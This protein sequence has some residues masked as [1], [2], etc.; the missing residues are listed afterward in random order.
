MQKPI[1]QKAINSVERQMGLRACVRACVRRVS[2][3]LAAGALAC[4]CV[5]A[6]L[7]VRCGRCKRR[8]WQWIVCAA[9]C[10]RPVTTRGSSRLA[11][12]RTDSAAGCRCHHS[13]MKSAC[14]RNTYVHTCIRSD[15]YTYAD[16]LRERERVPNEIGVANS[17]QHPCVSHRQ[18]RVTNRRN[19]IE[20]S[21]S[22]SWSDFETRRCE[23]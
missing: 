14:R 18:T 9:H 23:V 4:V 7:R 1:M 5:S 2:T 11:M 19:Q 15:I 17:C 13:R 12:S 22:I 10:S 21:W 6:C 16:K 20:I 3:L 8:W